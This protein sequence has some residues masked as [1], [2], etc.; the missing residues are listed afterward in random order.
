MRDSSQ[1]VI[2]QRHRP[3][4][5]E[6][7]DGEYREKFFQSDRAVNQT[8]KR[9]VRPIDPAREDERPFFADTSHNRFGN[10]QSR[11]RIFAQPDVVGAIGNAGAHA[12]T[13]IGSIRIL[14]AGINDT[15]PVQVRDTGK[16]ADDECVQG[17]GV[18]SSPGELLLGFVRHREHGQINLVDG[19]VEFFGEREREVLRRGLRAFLVKCSALPQR[20]PRQPDEEQIRHG[21]DHRDAPDKNGAGLGDALAACLIVHVGRLCGLTGSSTGTLTSCIWKSV[22]CRVMN[23]QRA[24]TEILDFRT[25]AGMLSPMKLKDIQNEPDDRRLPID[26]VGVKSLRYPVQV[27]DKAHSLQSTIATVQ[28]TV[29]LPHHF[30]GTHMSRFIEVLS[31]HGPVVHVDNIR[32]I[33]E[34]LTAR[35]Q[36]DCAHLDFEFPFFLEKRAPVTGAPGL[37]DY[38]ARFRATLE[39][40][41]MNFEVTVVV[42]VTTL[43]PC[44]KAIS[45]TGAHNQRG[46]V[47]LAVRCR[48]PMWLEDMIRLVEDSASSELYSLL[49]RP[50]EKAVTE[51]AYANPV[52]VEDLV[53][54]VALRCEADAN[55]RWYR[56]EAENFESIHNHNAYALIEKHAAV[57]PRHD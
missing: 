12:G 33:L 14:P 25:V 23:R 31:S 6:I 44:S 56:V 8:G 2:A 18:N 20:K 26:R 34:Q 16:L 50:D 55:V 35:L 37:M 27:R 48:K 30:K 29:D 10:N 49:K 38:T 11:L 52:F 3:V 51:L 17:L 24:G 5:A 53:R 45:E 21:C 41:R 54:N 22:F 46:H 28:L 7:D 36:S 43:C 39:R 42:P 47:T 32:N 19:V 15:Q 57:P 9:T 13:D 40:G 1:L 4:A